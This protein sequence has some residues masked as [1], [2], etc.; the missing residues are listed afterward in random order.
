MTLGELIKKRRRELRMSQATLA[1]LAGVTRAAIGQWEAGITAPS[2]RHMPAV[3]DALGLEPATVAGLPPVGLRDLDSQLAARSI[4]LMGMDDYDGGHSGAGM[5]RISI[6]GDVPPDAIAVVVSDKSMQP[7]IDSGDVI[8]VSRAVIPV[9]GDHV[10][11]RVDSG[12]VV[13]EYRPRGVDSK[14][15]PVF[16][17]VSLSADYPTITCNSVNGYK[18]LGTVVAYWRMRRRPQA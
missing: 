8:V 11:A 5:P 7:E 14:G 10:V 9:A 3:I 15:E 17:L 13:R 6:A 2:R 16:D 12:S 4:P 18:V 1:D